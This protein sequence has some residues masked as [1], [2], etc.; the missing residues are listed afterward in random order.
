[1]V[2]KKYASEFGDEPAWTMLL[3]NGDAELYLYQNANKCYLSCLAS[4]D[5]D[6][7]TSTEVSASEARLLRDE[8]E[9]EARKNGCV[10][11]RVGRR[12]R[13]TPRGTAVAWSAIERTL[14]VI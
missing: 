1:M 4:V 14:K 12:P 3:T 6:V 13:V 8:F 7:A 2:E 11:K 9:A 5:S 10:F